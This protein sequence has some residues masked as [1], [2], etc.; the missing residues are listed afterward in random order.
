MQSII[1]IFVMFDNQPS[2]LRVSAFGLSPQLHMLPADCDRGE[3][4]NFAHETQEDKTQTW[5]EYTEHYLNKKHW[6]GWEIKQKYKQY[7]L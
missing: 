7:K 1:M 4:T 3:K 6:G 2:F 5:T